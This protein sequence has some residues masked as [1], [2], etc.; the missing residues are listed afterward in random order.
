[1]KLSGEEEFKKKREAKHGNKFDYSTSVYQAYNLEVD[2]ICPIH[3]T[4]KQKP[5]DHC[6]SKLRCTF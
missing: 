5:I 3:G 1:M 6:R 2:I 4:F